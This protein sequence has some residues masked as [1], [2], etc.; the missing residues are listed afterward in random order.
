MSIEFQEPGTL[1]GISSKAQRD[2]GNL[3]VR[4]REGRKALLLWLTIAEYPLIYRYGRESFTILPGFSM[5]S[6]RGG[7]GNG[8]IELCL[9]HS[10]NCSSQSCLANLDLSG[11]QLWNTVGLQ[12]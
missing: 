12:Q 10:P 9:I 3:H 2:E 5:S 4:F 7:T 11:N 1:E 6:Y 8:Y